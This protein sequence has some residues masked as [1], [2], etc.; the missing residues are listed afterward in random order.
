[1]A[2]LANEPPHTTQAP[3]LIEARTEMTYWQNWAVGGGAILTGVSAS[4]GSAA[5][6]INESVK[7]NTDWLAKWQVPSWRN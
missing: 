1:M 2:A 7:C 6:I 4:A 5:A 3:E